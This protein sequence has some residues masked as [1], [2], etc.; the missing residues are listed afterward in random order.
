[1]FREVRRVLRPDGTVWLNLG[2]SYC[3]HPQG[4]HGDAS[5]SGLTNPARQ[6]RVAADAG[7]HRPSRRMRD[8]EGIKPK[9]LIGVPWLVA[10]AL[11]AD[12]W[13]LRADVVWA[14]PNPMPES[15]RD[16]PTRSHEFV[17][18]LTRSNTTRFWTHRDG[19]GQRVKPDPDWLWVNRETGV[20]VREARE[21]EE[22]ARLNL[23]RGHDYYYDADAIA[24]PR[25]GTRST[26]SSNGAQRERNRGGRTDD[27]T[28][29]NGIDLEHLG[30]VR[31][32]RDVWTIATR[33]YKGAHFACVDVETEALTP[34]GWRPHDELVDG[35]E[36]AAYNPTTERLTWQRATIHRYDYVGQLVALDSRDLS[37]RLT[38][39]HRCLTRSAR[40]HERVVLAEALTPGMRLPVAAK[41][42]LPTGTY[43][44]E[45]WAALLGWW[46]AEGHDRGGR[47]GRIYQSQSANPRHVATIRELLLMLNADFTEHQRTREWRGRPSI[48]VEFCLRGDVMDVLRERA[49]GRKLTHETLAAAPDRRSRQ[50][51][52]AALI[53]GDGHRR[54]D[55]RTSIVQRDRDCIDMI[56]MLAIS[57][58]Y[59]AYVTQ[60]ADTGVHTLYLTDH[61]WVGLRG[62]NGTHDPIRQERY[63]GVVWCPSVAASFWLAR[64][65]GK[66]FITGNT[67][68]TDLAEPCVLAGAPARACAECGAPWARLSRTELDESV[69]PARSVAE[70]PEVTLDGQG[71][72][73][74]DS[75]T[76]GHYLQ[77]TTLGYTPTCSC[78]ADAVPGVVLDPFAGAGTV[79]VVCGWHGREF[80]GIELKQAH[81]DLAHERIAREGKPSGRRLEPAVVSDDQ[82]TLEVG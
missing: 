15:V 33:P 39:N 20:E 43:T 59:R 78:D 35:D 41:F 47:T 22:W 53:D 14:K 67:F 61:R 11:R 72:N 56:Q 27:F 10:F 17:F 74:R 23:W 69:P 1:V 8:W 82:M 77:R 46:I 66:P 18:L 3:G 21:G 65:D 40:G 55:G 58:G 70:I 68:P 49:P 42:D 25:V 7:Q 62:T 2:D 64:R 60:R 54:P 32:R 6:A 31:N 37:Q 48:E 51:L 63:R 26:D 44:D 19:R 79:G 57:L 28:K 45:A 34:Y 50:A 75:A 38:P 71:R 36:I 9:D 24:E 16:R 29:P 81:A 5:T 4:N 52:L 80:I 73:G 12:G 13:H 76:F 30:G